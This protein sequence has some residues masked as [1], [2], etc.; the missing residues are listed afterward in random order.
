MT[1]LTDHQL[2]LLEQVL[3]H[4][5]VFVKDRSDIRVARSLDKQGLVSLSSTKRG[6]SRLWFC[7]CVRF[8]IPHNNAELPG[9]TKLSLLV[10]G[11]SEGDE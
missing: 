9:V 11:L 10:F 3:T 7:R 1:L 6:R 8:P 4:G 2:E 5:A